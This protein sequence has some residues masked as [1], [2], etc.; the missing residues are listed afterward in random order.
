MKKK[1]TNP[2]LIVILLLAPVLT[3]YAGSLP[4]G[5]VV[6]S[7]LA[8]TC[9]S[10]FSYTVSSTTRA[11]VSNTLSTV[12]VLTICNG[13]LLAVGMLTADVPTANLRFIEQISSNENVIF[14]GLPVPALRIP[15]DV[16]IEYFNRSFG[17]YILI[18]PTVTGTL[19]ETFTPYIDLNNNRLF[20]PETECLGQPAILNYVITNTAPPDLTTTFTL[21]T[22]SWTDAS[23]WSCG[24]IPQISDLAQIK[25][26]VTLPPNFQ[27]EAM[28]VVF[29]AGQRLLFG[30]GSTL[31]MGINTI[32]GV[33]TGTYTY[34]NNPELGSQY[35][36]FE[37]RADGSLIVNSEN[38]GQPYRA[39]GTWSLNGTAFTASYTYDN[40]FTPGENTLQSVTANFDSITG[41][42]T[43]GI[44]QNTSPINGYAGTFTLTKVN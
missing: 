43:A 41:K 34:D 29:D 12:P 4:T 44:W 40:G 19:S 36:S 22:G 26:V 7:P 8:T 27:A 3:S 5:Q 18:N 15:T 38:Y 17:A 32:Q 14:E 11:F 2:L 20:N 24:R 35:F 6:S 16:G 10:T 33:F 21:K 1:F 39:T 28:Q 25:H 37:I 31:R 42:L 23:V 13:G 30:T 9:P